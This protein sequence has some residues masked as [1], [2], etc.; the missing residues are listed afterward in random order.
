MSWFCG[1]V[2]LTAWRGTALF[3]F[4]IVAVAYFAV[5]AALSSLSGA[6]GRRARV[7]AAAVVAAGS[8]L[9]VSR[10]LGPDARAWLAH[11]YLVAGY[12]L[13]ALLIARSPGRFEAWL[14]R[15]E[16]F[17]SF[18]SFGSFAWIREICEIAYLCCYPVVPAAFLTVYLKGSIADVDGFWTSVLA[19]GYVCYI[20]LPWLVSRPPRI[21]EGSMTGGSRVRDLNLHVLDRFSHGWNTFPSGHVAVAVAAA[22]S[23]IS[24]APL[25]GVAFVVVAIGIAIGSVSGRYH[26]LIDTLA[27]MIVGVLSWAIT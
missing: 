1:A 24:V 18:G 4:E 9:A 16:S 5:I 26:Y 2:H 13:P 22:L 20:S 25:A 11:V 6:S 21:V 12:W 8:I 7:G 3:T 17:G 10:F 27:G 14:R 19:A 23:V 15:T